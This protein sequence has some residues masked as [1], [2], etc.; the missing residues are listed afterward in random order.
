[1]KILMV[2]IRNGIGIAAFLSV[3]ASSAPAQEVLPYPIHSEKNGFLI[4]QGP[5]SS[6]ICE[7]AVCTPFGP[8][9]DARQL[10]RPLKALFYSL[11]CTF[12]PLG[13]GYLLA[14]IEDQTCQTIGG[15]V[16]GFGLVV[17]PSM[18][19]FYAHDGL[20]GGLGIGM[21]VIGVGMITAGLW[22]L[23]ETVIEEGESGSGKYSAALITGGTVLVMGSAVWNMVSAPFSA[24]R[25]NARRNVLGCGI[26]P[27]KGPGSSRWTGF[28]VRFCVSF[29]T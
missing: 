20:K 18:G 28:M 6:N 12:V 15:A 1:M 23:I 2:Q 4:F 22:D 11:G 29:G 10:K 17:G 26:Q 21:R 14:L 3:L 19:N 7:P 27:V 9:T 5:V 24:R 16:G 8:A 13:A 25:Y